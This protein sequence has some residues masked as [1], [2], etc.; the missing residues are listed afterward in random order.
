MAQAA[1]LHHAPLLLPHEGQ[2]Q[3]E[4]EGDHKDQGPQNPNHGQLHLLS[5]HH[6]EAP[7]EPQNSQQEGRITHHRQAKLGEKETH[8]AA[9]VVSRADGVIGQVEAEQAQEQPQGEADHQQTG[10][11]QNPGAGVL[12][13]GLP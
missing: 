6:D 10:Q 11:L 2:I 7:G 8:L 1:Q 13:Q 4:G 12:I 9:Q 5:G 3:D